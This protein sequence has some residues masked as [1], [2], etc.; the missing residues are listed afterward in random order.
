L[1]GTT[2][3]QSE[4]EYVILPNP[5]FPNVEPAGTINELGLDPVIPGRVGVVKLVLLNLTSFDDELVMFITP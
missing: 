5:P 1:L 3:I 4:S 2:I